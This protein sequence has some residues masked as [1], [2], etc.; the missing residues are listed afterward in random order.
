[1]S[2]EYDKLI[3]MRN[4]LKKSVHKSANKQ[5]IIEPEFGSQVNEN[6]LE[7]GERY[8]IVDERYN[9]STYD[10]IGTLIGKYKIDDVM[11][12]KFNEIVLFDKDDKHYINYAKTKDEW[13]I[14]GKPVI[15]IESPTK[16]IALTDKDKKPKF[17]EVIQE[18]N[19][20]RHYVPP[21]ED[22]ISSKINSFIFPKG[23]GEG[24][25]KKRWKNKR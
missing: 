4:A 23:K 9:Y 17:Y 16:F 18:G 1:M 21:S 2:T 6:D 15:R 20:T 24:K 3:D 11:H 14:F 12:Y 8:K 19:N 22:G 25:E 7:V 10:K 13:V 5:K